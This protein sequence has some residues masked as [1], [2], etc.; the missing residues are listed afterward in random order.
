MPP[1]ILILSAPSGAGKTSL[2]RKLVATRPDVALTVSHTTRPKRRGEQHAVDYFFVGMPAFEKMIVADEFIEHA[3]VFGNYYGT[4]ADTI[5][6]L[7]TGGKHAI[8]EIDWQ[9]ARTV[10]EKY[11]DVQ[12]VFIMPP[13][14]E[15]LEERLR[16]RQL[17]ADDVITAR[18]RAAQ[19]EMSHRDEYD[20]VI[21]ND[22]FAR[23]FERLAA[24]LPAHGAA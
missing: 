23:A 2:A 21:T 20:A 17:D 13:S 4:S 8:L 6:N 9:G 18:M 16:A 19:D 24:L 14:L 5:N 11:P 12:S 10:R 3:N 15:A 1:Q 7:I 22:H